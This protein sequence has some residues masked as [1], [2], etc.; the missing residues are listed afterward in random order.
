MPGY[1]FFIETK[2]L[3]CML[4][5]LTPGFIVKLLTVSVASLV[6][7]LIYISNNLM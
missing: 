3:N 4:S 2:K 5:D 1:A 7:E 6:T